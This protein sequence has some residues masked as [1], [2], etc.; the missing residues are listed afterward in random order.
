MPSPSKKL[1]NFSPRLGFVYN[2]DGNGRTTFRV[3]AGLLYDSVA[4]FIPYRMVAQNPPFGPQV[5]NTNGPYQFSN[6]WAQRPRRQSVPA[7]AAR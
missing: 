4:T 2:P 3:G 7:A 5:T 6:P 1:A